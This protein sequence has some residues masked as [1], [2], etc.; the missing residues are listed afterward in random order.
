MDYPSKWDECFTHGDTLEILSQLSLS[1]C[2]GIGKE[3][4]EISRLIAERDWRRLCEYELDYALPLDSDCF[5]DLRQAL[6]FFQKLETLDAGYDKEK[7][8]RG[9]FYKSEM[10]CAKAN[11][12]FRRVAEGEISF[13]PFVESVLHGAQ[14]KIASCLG[15]VPTLSALAYRFGPGAT[16][17]VKRRM[18]CAK[19]KLSDAPRCSA[20]LQTLAPF[21]LEECPG[22][23]QVH[24]VSEHESGWTVPLT[25][26][27]GKLAFVPKNAKTYRSIMIE[28]N[29]N[30]L[31]QSGIGKAMER[32]LRGVG[33]DIR[34]QTRN[35]RLAKYGS[36]TGELATLDLSSASDS[37]CSELVANL[38]PVEWYALLSCART[39]IVSDAGE[40]LYLQKFSS[41]GNGFT[42]PLQTLIFWSLCV[43]IA[44]I[45]GESSF[46]INVYGDDIIVPTNIALVCTAVLQELGFSINL[47]KSYW[48][49]RVLFRESCGTDYFGGVNIRPLYIKGDLS[50]ADL[51]RVYNFYYRRGDD[52]RASYVLRHIPEHIRLYGP[53]GYGDGHLVTDYPPYRPHRR[54]LGW[55]GFV[56]DSY[57]KKGKR[58]CALLPGDRALPGYSVY[59]SQGAAVSGPT[60][61]CEVKS[62]VSVPEAVIPGWKG[63]KRIS[64]YTLNP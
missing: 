26:V 4:A 44:D 36:L 21:I 61:H 6:G 53:D 49:R 9:K 37:I 62:G 51:F 47:E 14:R 16:T 19:V 52:L 28:P 50:Y 58:F 17:S 10:S 13:S 11:S 1:H 29:L 23:S 7:E 12:L 39:G 40:S 57:V 56:F 15:T 18:A 3:G 32:R 34:D 60:P 2:R 42:F 25:I 33:L 64:I 41:M 8:A 54:E 20:D 38:L 59:L 45:C 35:Q 5:R 63:Y 27:E 30:T 31:I 48:S 43:S 46:F 22:Y 55:A 24:A